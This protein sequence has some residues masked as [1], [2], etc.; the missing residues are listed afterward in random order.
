MIQPLTDYERKYVRWYVWE[1]LRRH[2][3][4]RISY[5]GLSEYD[6]GGKRIAHGLDLD[7]KD[8]FCLTW[9]LMYPISPDT[10]FENIVSP[11]WLFV[12]RY[13]PLFEHALFF[14]YTYDP[15]HWIVQGSYI[16][17]LVNTLLSQS[18][19]MKALKKVLDDWW[20]KWKS[21]YGGK[22]QRNATPIRVVETEG[23]YQRILV[24][25][26]APR[27]KIVNEVKKFLGDIIGAPTS[28][29]SFRKMESSFKLW[30]LVDKHKL[31]VDEAAN[32]CKISKSTAYDRL[33]EISQ[34]IYGVS[35][36]KSRCTRYR[37]PKITSPFP[38]PAPEVDRDFEVTL[39]DKFIENL[40]LF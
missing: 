17:I 27:T 4:L 21:F 34:L 30:D 25:L 10:E 14:D 36:I 24:N 35:F 1:P 33:N 29:H 5:E 18:M 9:R 13:K 28:R 31:D 37:T 12:E 8:S 7:K 32:V 22:R 38:T 39:Q 6:V 11:E 23:R 20:P 19:V 26:A 16:P 3:D 2:E 40:M 15:D